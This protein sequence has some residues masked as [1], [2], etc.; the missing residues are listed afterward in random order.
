MKFL[1][2]GYFDVEA[3]GAVPEADRDAVMKVCY[4]MCIPFRATGKVIE[5][6]ELGGASSAKCIRTRKGKQTVT[7]G[8]F[9]ETKEQVGGFF[10]VEADSM[11]EAIKV[12][13]MHPGAVM[14]EHYG[15]AIEVRPFH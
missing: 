7:D 2:L 5:E 14:G 4:A 12:A 9:I 10:I 13:S 3:F 15:F 1:C 11:D 6:G 8:P